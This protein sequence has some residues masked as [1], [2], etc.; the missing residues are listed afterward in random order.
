MSEI[1]ETIGA[2]YRD[3]YREKLRVIAEGFE[4]AGCSDI[5]VFLRAVRHKLLE[6]QLAI[7]SLKAK[8]RANPPNPPSLPCDLEK[9]G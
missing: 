2:D 3:A 6:Q 9:S 5:G 1:T 7:L 4:A 8:L